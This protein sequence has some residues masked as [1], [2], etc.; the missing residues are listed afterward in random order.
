MQRAEADH[1][2]RDLIS[3]RAVDAMH[4]LSHLQDPDAIEKYLALILTE[5]WQEGHR[6]GVMEKA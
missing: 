1:E 2:I 6:A 5:A 4:V 3:S